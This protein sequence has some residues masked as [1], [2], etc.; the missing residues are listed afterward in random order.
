MAAH[1]LET[2]HMKCRVTDNCRLRYTRSYSPVIHYISPPVIY[3]EAWTEV[4][5]DPKSTTSL[6]QDLSSD[7]MPF[8]NTRISGALIDFEDTVDH[9]TYFSHWNKN[10]VK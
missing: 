6:I 8:I 7:E 9:E 5:F 3:N 10:R 1:D 4:W 2:V